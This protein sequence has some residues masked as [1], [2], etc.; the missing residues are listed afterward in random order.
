MPELLARRR[1]LCG[2][3]LGAAGSP[4]NLIGGDRT[5]PGDNSS[6]CSQGPEVSGSLAGVLEDHRPGQPSCC[7]AE[8]QL[9]IF[10]RPQTPSG[11]PQATGSAGLPF[12]LPNRERGKKYPS[13]WIH[14]YVLNPGKGA[15]TA[16]LVI[17]AGIKMQLFLALPVGSLSSPL[18]VVPHL[19]RLG[20]RMHVTE[21]YTT[22][23]RQNLRE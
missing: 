3:R 13:S 20:E 8:S 21:T 7:S 9:S 4:E 1:L 2:H 18:S 5:T 17:H 15:G 10:P 11:L 14:F 23:P 16:L 22:W 12:C 19:R 6:P